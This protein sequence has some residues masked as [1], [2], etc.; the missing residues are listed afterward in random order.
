MRKILLT[1]A[2]VL[3]FAFGALAQSP[4]PAITGTCK[5]G[6][7]FSAQSR[8]GACSRHGGIEALG[9]APAATIPA[10]ASTIAAPATP[11][12]PVPNRTQAVAPQAAVAGAG[13]VWV[14]SATKVYHCSGD[15]Y[16]GKTKA[17]SYMPEAAAKADGDRP[18]HG[19]MCS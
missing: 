17:G 4:S 18:S 14:N 3:P 1:A 8:R 9:T 13:Q 15:R 2:M 7:A 19:K 12:A 16:Y 6:T 5:D 11:A 10:P